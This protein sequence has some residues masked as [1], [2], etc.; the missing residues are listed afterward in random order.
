MSAGAYV[1]VK[2]D[3]REKLP[4]ALEALS[5]SKDIARW[6]AVDGHYNLVL[7]LTDNR[8]SV[9]DKIR[10]MEGFSGLSSCELQTGGEEDVPLSTEYCYSY[11]FIEAERFKQKAVQTALAKN[12][13]VVFCSPV[14]GGCDLIALVRGESFDII[15]RT[16]NDFIRPLDGVLRLK[17]ERV[18]LLD[19]M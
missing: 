6:D 17:Q 4:A 16:V 18:I 7:R 14:S 15:D 9:E 8:K 19:R 2:F 10:K 12:E 11:V 3:N 13:A 5:G 1:L